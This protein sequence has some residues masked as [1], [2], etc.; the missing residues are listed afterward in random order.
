M[1][2]N[3]KICVFSILLVLSTYNSVSAYERISAQ[4]SNSTEVVETEIFEAENVKP[5]KG[6]LEKA[7]EAINHK[8]FNT[9][10]SYMNTYILSKPK[11]YEG[12]K[13]RGDAY[14]ALRRYDLA[15]S[16]YQSAVNL[17]LND[18]KLMTNTKYISAVI[19]GADKNEQL[20]NTELGNLYAR[21]MYAQKALN[22]TEYTTSY[23]NAIKYNS[24]IYLPQPKKSD[25]SQINCPQKYGKVINPQGIDVEIY[26]AITDIENKNFND[27]IYKLQKV[28][29]VYPKYY[30]GHYLYGVALVGLDSN[31]EAIFAFEKSVN[32]NPYDFE[33]LASL[34]EIYYNR[35]EKTFSSEDAKKSVEYFKKALKY[36][37]NCHTYYLY[38][39]LSE[40]QQGNNISAIDSFNK[41]LNLNPNDYNSK[42]YKAIAQYINGNYAEVIENTTALLRKHVSNYNSVL[43]LRALAY[44]KLNQTDKSLADLDEIQSNIEDIYNADVKVISD[45]EKTLDN[46]IYYLKAQI[47]H[48][49]GLGAASDMSKALK[50]P[51]IAQ[52]EKAHNAMLPYGDLLEKENI[53]LEE[54]NK[55]ESFYNT[56]LPKLLNSGVVITE[57]DVNNQYDYLRTTFADLGLTFDYENN[58]YKLTTIK[59]YP[60]KT[61]SS[62][63]VKKDLEQTNKETVPEIR[64]NPADINAT[65]RDSTPASELISK[66]PD[67]SLA[68]ILASNSLIYQ[69]IPATK[70]KE[71]VVPKLQEQ[72][73]QPDLK[74]FVPQKPAAEDVKSNNIS[75]GEIYINPDEKKTLLNEE[76]AQKVKK[77]IDEEKSF[78]NNNTSKSGT[79]YIIT[80]KEIKESRDIEIK[81]ET[82]TQTPKTQEQEKNYISEG[83]VVKAKEIKD[84]P[85]IK[86]KHEAPKQEQQPKTTNTISTT[87]SGA[88]IFTAPER[89]KTEDIVVKH[90]ASPSE[91]KTTK[92]EQKPV[93]QKNISEHKEVQTELTKEPALQKS[94]EIN[95]PQ[96]QQTPEEKIVTRPVNTKYA[97]VNPEDFGVQTKPTPVIT[98][99]DD[100]I[101][102]DNSSLMQDFEK[103]KDYLKD[104]QA[105]IDKH[106]EEKQN[107]LAKA[108]SNDTET[109]ITLPEDDYSI[110]EEDTLNTKPSTQTVIIPELNLPDKITE[111]AVTTKNELDTINLREKT[112]TES[113]EKAEKVSDKLANNTQILKNDYDIPT[114]FTEPRK[115]I[116]LPAQTK[117]ELK[118]QEQAIKEQIKAL[119]NMKKLEQEQKKAALAEEKARIKA[120]EKAQK[121]ADKQMQEFK[122]QELEQERIQA[123]EEAKA[124]KIAQKEEYKAQA[125][126][127]A[128]QLKQERKLA[129]LEAKAKKAEAKALANSQKEKLK[130]EREFAKTKAKQ[131][132]MLKKEQL[133]T[134]RAKAKA[135]A[136]VL[137]TQQKEA[138]KVKEAIIRT[139]KAKIADEEKQKQE[140]TRKIIK[141]KSETIKPVSDTKKTSSF[142]WKAFLS[143]FKK[144]K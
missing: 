120:E 80:A 110:F 71:T 135:E 32:L 42:Y 51:L 41:A 99:F 125:Q 73:Q 18:D 20:Q 21:L 87:P 34:G 70:P 25:I 49:Q 6:T 93:P 52:L 47:E 114:V 8:D 72:E 44:N 4:D 121:E 89:K 91:E 101:E 9:A 53:T 134:E 14:Y 3:K 109:A 65:L 38:I 100:V 23:E 119:D 123:K 36:N 85:D 19:L 56:S 40:L 98:D 95:T 142:S 37:P 74:N 138:Q 118:A 15:Q 106:L 13:L 141:A 30:L 144:S 84:S 55:F 46:Y 54:F 124:I 143:K 136:D 139:E 97:I 78:E 104:L 10:I 60:A 17:K 59:D 62:K 96:A 39:G 79:P 88:M 43:Y 116:T 69:D 107:N 12:Y 108:F 58:N 67:Q 29:S 66:N 61:Y 126:A 117:S 111:K 133:K 5:N 22:N 122:K 1:K 103:D 7:Q 57:D 83:L 75:S 115:E 48:Q 35:A 33:S 140:Q 68:Q 82:Q 137:K 112:L 127:K 132:A 26:G 27:A 90:S 94:Q 16:D 63:L 105:D 31:E 128:Q 131:E 92:E 129:K 50:N 45:K 81:R 28:T 64:T 2:I 86:I 76:N 77:I 24:H 11:K 113:L 130:K 102:L